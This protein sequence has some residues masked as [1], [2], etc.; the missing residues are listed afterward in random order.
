MF[1]PPTLQSRTGSAETNGKRQSL[2]RCPPEVLRWE[3]NLDWQGDLRIEERHRPTVTWRNYSGSQII[4]NSL[5]ETSGS[6][7]EKGKKIK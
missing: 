4:T 7:R 2:P 5:L 1:G 3:H 6:E